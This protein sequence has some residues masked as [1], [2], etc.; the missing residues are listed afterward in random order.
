MHALLDQGLPVV[1]AVEKTVDGR[2][3]RLSVNAS[4]HELARASHPELPA[5]AA[6]IADDLAVRYA[7]MEA[8]GRFADPFFM[9]SALLLLPIV[10][11]GR[12]L[13]PRWD[14]LVS[15]GTQPQAREILATVP[16]ERREAIVW[17]RLARAK[18]LDMWII[19]DVVAVLDLAPSRRIADD[20]LRRL[21]MP[22]VREF[23]KAAVDE[24]RSRIRDLARTHKSL[25]EALARDRA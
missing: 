3:D 6:L 14:R 24:H 16:E 10:R 5:R 9:T 17:R 2:G 19:G 8:E 18:P 20:I 25:G 11:S 4:F 15:F 7:V 1:D 21:E 13:E 12:P 23:L 22:A